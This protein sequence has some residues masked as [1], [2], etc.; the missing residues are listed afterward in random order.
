MALFSGRVDSFNQ[1]QYSGLQSCW[2]FLFWQRACLR[3]CS[4]WSHL[5][6]TER[7]RIGDNA[8]VSLS[9]A[10]ELGPR[11]I[12]FAASRLRLLRPQPTADAVG[13]LLPLL[14]SYVVSRNSVFLRQNLW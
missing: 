2:G 8:S 1:S 5:I 13:Y 9:R 10:T 3:G 14:R 12:P 4:C 6:D 11:R 7:E